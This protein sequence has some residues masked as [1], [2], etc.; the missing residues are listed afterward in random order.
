VGKPDSLEGYVP[1]QVGEF[2]R[3]YGTVYV[4]LEIWRRQRP[5]G[6]E[7]TFYMPDGGRFRLEFDMQIRRL[8]P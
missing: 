2:A 4:P 1:I 3:R 7:F 8:K 6:R 5:A